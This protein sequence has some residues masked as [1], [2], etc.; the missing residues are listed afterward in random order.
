MEKFKSPKPNTRFTT[1]IKNIKIKAKDNESFHFSKSPNVAKNPSNKNFIP[2][3]NNKKNMSKNGIM[4][5]SYSVTD[6]KSKINDKQTTIPSS[7]K[8]NEN[9]IKETK[10]FN[11]QNKGKGRSLEK[12]PSQNIQRNK[13][14]TTTNNSNN[15]NNNDLNKKKDKIKNVNETGKKNIINNTKKNNSAGKNS[16]SN[17]NVNKNKNNN[18]NN[19]HNVKNNKN[20]IKNNNNNN[21]NEM[22]KQSLTNKNNN[23]KSKTN[24]NDYNNIDIL[25][26]INIDQEKSNQNQRNNYKNYNII[27]NNIDSS[28]PI[29]APDIENI[30]FKKYNSVCVSINNNYNYNVSLKPSQPENINNLLNQDLIKQDNNNDNNKTHKDSKD[31]INNKNNMKNKEKEKEKVKEMNWKEKLM[32]IN[33]Q[34]KDMN[35]LDYRKLN[36]TDS[37]FWKKKNEMNNLRKDDKN[38]MENL[39][40]KQKIKKLNSISTDNNNS[41]MNI[42]NNSENLN[43]E[44]KNEPK[45]KNGI[46]GFLRSFKVMLE[47]FNLR[48]KNKTRNNTDTS[49]NK[50]ANYTKNNIKE[51]LN[52]SDNNSVIDNKK[53]NEINTIKPA[54]TETNKNKK[55]IFEKKNINMNKKKEEKNNNNN[56][57]NDKL[58]DTSPIPNNPKNINICLSSTNVKNN[59]NNNPKENPNIN[60]P[61]ILSYSQ[62]N[63]LKNDNEIYVKRRIESSYDIM[64]EYNINNKSEENQKDNSLFN[65]FGIKN[66]KLYK[67]SLDNENNNNL[68]INFYKKNVPPPLNDINLNSAYV[69]KT[70]NKIYSPSISNKSEKINNNKYNLND[71]DNLNNEK[72]IKKF[73]FKDRNINNPN[74]NYS[75]VNANYKSLNLGRENIFLE[76]NK[77][78]EDD[79]KDKYNSENIE[80]N[81]NI[82]AEKKIQ[83]IKI[84]INYKKDKNNN[85]I[86]YDSRTP[87]NDQCINSDQKLFNTMDDFL[88]TPKPK[89]EIETCIITFNKNKNKPAKV[90]ENNL[91]TTPMNYAQ[92]NNFNNNNYNLN[93]NN[94]NYN[95]NNINNNDNYN[96]HNNNYNKP[97]LNENFTNYSYSNIHD[98]NNINNNNLRNV[99]SKPNNLNNNL[100]QSEKN[101][102]RG[103]NL[104]LSDM[105]M[106]NMNFDAPKPIKKMIY[107]NQKDKINK[108][109]D[110]Q[111]FDNDNNSVNS[112]KSNESNES[113]KT[114]ISHITNSIYSKPFKSLHKNNNKNINNN[115]NNNIIQNIFNTDNNK[116]NTDLGINPSHKERIF[117]MTNPGYSKPNIDLSSEDIIS[118]DYSNKGIYYKRKNNDSLYNTDLD[119]NPN[120]RNHIP[121]QVQVIYTKKN[122]STK[123]NNNNNLAINNV[124]PIPSYNFNLTNDN[125]VNNI[126][127]II[128]P[129]ITQ[130]NSSLIHKIYGYYM[131]H[132]KIEEKNYYFSKEFLKILKM[133]LKDISFCT[134]YCYKIIQKPEIKINYIDKKRIKKSHLPISQNCF[135]TKKNSI[136]VIPNGIIKKFI[137]EEISKQFNDDYNLLYKLSDDIKI[138]HDDSE[139]LIE[140]KGEKQI[141]LDKELKESIRIEE[142]EKENNVN[143]LNININNEINNITRKFSTPTHALKENEDNEVPS[144]QFACISDNNLP[145]SAQNKIIS[146][147]I[148]L[149]NKNNYANKND[150]ISANK[151][152]SSTYNNIKLN[153]NDTLYIKK[154]PNINN[155]NKVLL[156]QNNNNRVYNKIEDDKCKTYVKEHKRNIDNININ[157][158]HTDDDN[159]YLNNN[160]SKSNKIICIDID[161]SKEQKKIKEQKEKELLNESKEIKAYKRPTLAP[162]L[163]YQSKNLKNKIDTITINYNQD[164]INNNNINTNLNQDHLKQEIIFKLNIVSK[165]NILLIVDELLNLLTKKIIIDNINNKMNNNKIRLS[166]IEILTN[167]NCFAEI[168]INKAICE[169]NKIGI[170][171]NVCNELCAR[172]RNEINF[173]GNSVEE[174]LTTLLAEDCKLKFEELIIDNTYNINDKKLLGII[175]FICEL[176]NFR[177]ISLDIGYFCF[178]KLCNKYNSFLNDSGNITK[179]YYLDIIVEFVIKY[180]KIIYIEQNMKYLERIQDYIDNELN[181]LL[182]NDMGLPDFLKF[183]IINLM[184]SKNNKWMI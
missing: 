3:K 68:N 60:T 172:L 84:N 117:N 111:E 103:I 21:K 123:N 42:S 128:R 71:I 35:N 157:N 118:N 168:I 135:F 2:V 18:N 152:L 99:Y 62:K 25:E 47:P 73:S 10:I 43:E 64:K 26:N 51:L 78:I 91:Y 40:I 29:N 81:L 75:N 120:N 126:K 162:L 180:G 161:L 100:N 53:N 48:K 163:D 49:N 141:N 65:I 57:S 179:Y 169:I 160:S 155:N 156:N 83:E 44:K 102:K 98:T 109:I 1:E 166:F 24:L 61:Q 22:G 129:K 76:K 106:N 87:L 54:K 20:I 30:P 139:D 36:H 15:N 70:K 142:L 79:I 154:K 116:Y 31:N 136:V 6:L 134:K 80:E 114:S 63:I 93:N 11:I 46:L 143:N 39:N 174:D 184:K 153:Q 58:Y 41:I 72:E 183:K 12:V 137:N 90:Y 170:F 55:S 147:E 13:N 121:N 23:T 167:E 7:K 89:A 182:S 177:I 92:N 107:T 8:K 104:S 37:N 171:A 94:N 110:S 82:N 115:P 132:P 112:E 164:N 34:K 144:P 28:E 16:N 150:D 159:I 148:Q 146:I 66:N 125:K 45:K 149:N 96:F 27:N 105:D 9:I 85:T 124:T 17:N 33:K 130:K 119:I 74:P 176:I 101:I 4:N 5:P 77:L 145:K 52:K 69:K 56:L 32:K 14:K 122:K 127:T 67:K 131:R 59:N 178:D 19:N 175:L 38:K 88:P 151:N 158:F 133:P 113:A 108:F 95:F 165:N 97:Q 173:R 181:H 86:S 140:N 138:D 50:S